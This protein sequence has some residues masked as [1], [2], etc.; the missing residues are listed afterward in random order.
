M[1]AAPFL[2]LLFKNRKIKF[3]Q[4]SHMPE[5]HGG[6]YYLARNCTESWLVDSEWSLTFF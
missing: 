6:Y 3:L 4:R 1:L 2:F 5:V